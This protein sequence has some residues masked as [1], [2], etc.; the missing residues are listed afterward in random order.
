[1][2]QEP[3]TDH[4]HSTFALHPEE[5]KGMLSSHRPGQQPTTHVDTQ[6]QDLWTGL[7]QDVE[8]ANRQVACLLE[9]CDCF[10]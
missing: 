1:M 4:P 10:I 9:C 3:L 2:A 7:D 6:L 8:R 5:G